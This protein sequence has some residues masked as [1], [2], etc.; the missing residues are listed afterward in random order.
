[1]VNKKDKKIKQRKEETVSGFIQEEGNHG[2][3]EVFDI[4]PY[5]LKEGIM[6]LFG[7]DFVSKDTSRVGGGG[8]RV[9]R[10]YDDGSSEDRTYRDG[11]L[12]DITDHESNG[13]SHSHNVGHGLL[14][15]FKGSRK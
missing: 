9:T 7:K 11:K 2:C 6:G 14:G 10:H 1:L 4:Q 8:E 5:R 13:S 12:V 3:P 15:P